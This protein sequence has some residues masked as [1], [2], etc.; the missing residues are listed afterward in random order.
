M[1]LLNEDDI[2]LPIPL[3]SVDKSLSTAVE[4]EHL[5]LYGDGV[6]M[7]GRILHIPTLL[8]AERITEE[9]MIV[10]I[11]GDLADCDLPLHTTVI[12]RPAASE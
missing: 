10:F 5:P 12:L 7:K 2:Y 6:T 4:G 8:A 3:V 1:Y 11:I 9:I